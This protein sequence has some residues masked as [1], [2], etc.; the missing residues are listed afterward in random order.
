MI[1]S[2]DSSASRFQEAE[3]LLASLFSAGEQVGTKQVEAV[4]AAHPQ[5]E[6]ELRGLVDQM[7]G[8]QCG[9]DDEA[10]SVVAERERFRR[11]VAQLADPAEFAQRYELWEE[12]GRGGMGVVYRAY[13]RRLSRSIALKVIR[14]T[15][16]SVSKGA[17]AAPRTRAWTRFLNEVRITAR[18]DHPGIVPVHEVGVNP[19]GQVYFTM[20]LVKGRTLG[21]VLQSHR[22]A[23][24]D[25][26][27]HRVLALFQRVCEAVGFAH[28]Q[29]VVHR[30]LKPSNIMVGDFGEVYV[31]D[32][33][34]ARAGSAETEI[35]RA[36]PDVARDEL[37]LP[38]ALTREGELVGTPA[39]MS[40]E[41]AR[42]DVAGM[43]PWSDVY[44]IGAILYELISGLPPYVEPNEK[45][46]G[47]ELLQR[48]VAGPPRP[49]DA[50][51][52][53]LELVAICEKSLERD[54]SRRYADVR[55]LAQDIERWLNGRSVKALATGPWNEL[56]KWVGRNRA[57][58][59]ALAA[60]VLAVIGAVGV[61]WWKS[62]QVQAARLETMAKDRALG[63]AMTEARV[64]RVAISGVWN[65]LL[66][67]MNP[68]I[69]SDQPRTFTELLKRAST[70]V[71]DTES[72]DPG[73]RGH[74]LL[75]I[76]KTQNS[77][78]EP[79][80]AIVPLR[81]AVQLLGDAG[82]DYRREHAEAL[83]RLG[84]AEMDTGEHDQAEQHLIRFLERSQGGMEEEA[85]VSTCHALLSLAQE[86]I[87]TRRLDEADANLEAVHSLLAS[88]DGLA[89]D[90]AS[91]YHRLRA[92]LER[93][94][95]QLAESEASY[96]RS[97]EIMEKLGAPPPFRLGL[98]LSLAALL[99]EMQRWPESRAETE[100]ALSL[101]RELNSPPTS[102]LAAAFDQLGALANQENRL[103]EAEALACQGLELRLD[104]IGPTAPD[105]AR[106]W[107]N[108][109][110]VLIASRRLNEAAL[111]LSDAT[112][113][114]RSA[115]GD[116]HPETFGCWMTLGWL[117][118]E[119]GRG[120]TAI[121]AYR[122]ALA[123]F[124]EVSGMPPARMALLRARLARVLSRAGR[125]AE[126]E[127]Q[128]VAAYE[129]ALPEGP[130][131]EILRSVVEDLAV[132][133]ASARPRSPR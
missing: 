86:R 77:L 58:A 36:H 40:P 105:T 23:Q 117:R 22:Q 10:G 44:S 128:V 103:V 120:E 84:H 112:F 9:F 94:R 14:D 59:S 88:R 32:W 119:Q 72:L 122:T 17:P 64:S 90:F 33:G 11:I 50:R 2:P 45:P 1:D 42:G 104:S 8:L 66:D 109:A 28:G 47:V 3:D 15:V 133:S 99:Y 19:E 132:T 115:Y 85:A 91:Q 61:G 70:L 130:H 131:S 95:G 113:A 100:A 38:A 18:L 123:G 27:L 48:V 37:P 30:D 21:D 68:I 62:T 127:E 56:G 53:P 78:G 43:G 83:L 24:G 25:W 108:L 81:A 97:L 51:R 52:T 7:A 125:L 96:R 55:E 114:V 121:E 13:D 46:S 126:A 101:L 98:R 80:A 71:S 107:H 54:R 87:T 16:G 106:S 31:M 76:G 111:Q 89:S 73:T 34:V 60:C 92:L 57:L 4:I 69:Q 118:E 26:T 74:L 5:L 129:L 12:L 102:L 67:E 82:E 65:R 29:G 79:R 124:N 39:Y 6:H 41:Q 49:L 110:I 116:R 75:R 20:K 93:Q 35:P 63:E